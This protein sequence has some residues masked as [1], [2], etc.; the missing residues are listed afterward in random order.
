MSVD[1]RKKKKNL[2]PAEFKVPY[3]SFCNKWTTSLGAGK[4]GE[5]CIPH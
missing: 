1:D 3:M 4:E 5:S 2:F